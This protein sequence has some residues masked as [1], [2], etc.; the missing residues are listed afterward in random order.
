MIYEKLTAKC[1]SIT[2]AEYGKKEGHSSDLVPR[3]IHCFRRWQHMNNKSKNDD[4]NQ[5]QLAKEKVI[6][7][8]SLFCPPELSRTPSSF[9]LLSQ[10]SCA[11]DSPK[12]I[13]GL[14]NVKALKGGPK[15][16]D[17]LCLSG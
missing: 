14:Y 15:E 8:L 4:I 17:I 3:D 16:N 2:E 9:S 11:N 10:P 6:G 12:R 5:V 7:S 13:F 1:Q